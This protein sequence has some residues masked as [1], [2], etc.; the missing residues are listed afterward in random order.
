MFTRVA[1]GPIEQRDF[2]CQRNLPLLTVFA[3]RR[4]DM[5]D[6]ADDPYAGFNDYSQA[7]DAQVR[8]LSEE[9]TALF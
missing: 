8:I 1:K 6:D 5:A 4:S 2:N 7:Y 9:M 3:S